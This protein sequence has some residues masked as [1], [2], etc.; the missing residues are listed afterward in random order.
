MR[1][2]FPA[3]QVSGKH[4]KTEEIREIGSLTASESDERPPISRLP[5]C[6]RFDNPACIRIIIPH[7]AQI[8]KPF[9]PRTAKKSAGEASLASPA[10]F[11]WILNMRRS[12][13]A[14]IFGEC[15]TMIFTDGSSFLRGA[16]LSVYGAVRQSVQ[17]LS[18]RR[19]GP[20]EI[21]ISANA[22]VISL[23]T[24]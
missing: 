12:S 4:R 13:G 17:S 24:A 3:R 19:T 7:F 18:I 2:R 6:D 16:S 8:V 20:P 9:P 14:R 22:D 15:R 5:R 11:Q 1:I 10:R 23:L 21:V